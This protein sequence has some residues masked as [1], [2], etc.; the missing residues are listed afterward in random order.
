MINTKRFIQDKRIDAIEGLVVR[1]FAGEEDFGTMLKLWYAA[2]DFNAFD[3]T[4]S[5]DKMKNLPKRSPNMI[6]DEHVLLFEYQEEPVGYGF[7]YWQEEQD[8]ESDPP[9][10]VLNFSVTL[11]ETAWNVGINEVVYD[12]L[13]ERILQM[14]K[15]LPDDKPKLVSVWRMQAA[16]SQIAF[17]KSKGFEPH[18]YFFEMVR[19]I[20]KP[21]DK[22]PL[23]E[24]IDIREVKPEHYRKIWDA[25]SE[26]FRDHW[27]YFEP[28]E[29]QFEA[30]Q[31]DEDFQPHLWKVAW[32]GN[33]VVGRVGNQLDEEENKE[34]GRKRGYT[35]D[36]SVRKA[37]RKRGIAKALIAE[38]IRMFKEMG[39]ED[40]GLGVDA[41]NPNGA[42]KLYTDM[43]YEELKN[44][45]SMILRKKI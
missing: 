32:D 17:Y 1:H 22:H 18:R 26:A 7:Y 37:W 31:D 21:L 19:P 27:G 33:E 15:T 5:L 14:A 24:G 29:D 40:T 8:G 28:S 30:W 34:F 36:I 45:T 23:P 35:E 6:L 2:R 4:Y 16:E 38:S 42:L 41:E 11:T 20:D 43:D 13:E 12:L 3:W 44:E 25:D 9:H 10:N 39:M